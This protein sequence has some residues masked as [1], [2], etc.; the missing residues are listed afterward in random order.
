MKFLARWQFSRFSLTERIL[1]FDRLSL[2]LRAGIPITQALGHIRDVSPTKS[3]RR[4]LSGVFAIITHGTT[5][6]KTLESFPSHFPPFEAHL[7]AIGEMSGKLPDN[8]AH[9]ASLLRRQRTLKRKV[10][11]ALL[12][13]LIIAIGA[14]CVTGFLIFYLFPKIIPVFAGLNV[15]LPFTTRFLIG[16]SNLFANHGLLLF[17]V[18]IIILICTAML[19]RLRSVRRCIDRLMFMLPFIRSLIRTY[20]VAVHMR[21]LAMLLE[22]G[23][24]LMP[25][26]ALARS[27]ISHASYEAALVAIEAQVSAG[28][29]LSGELGKYPHLFPAVTVQLAA[30]GELTGTLSRSLA[31]C[32]DLYE[33]E[34][35]ELTRRLATLI[36]PALMI[37]VGGIVGFVAIAIISP[38]YGITQNLNLR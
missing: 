27:G 22:S 32:A 15:P 12:Y 23:I 2:Y 1:L 8:L 18:F 4:V 16:T 33:E 17:V 34:L 9:L 19:L 28:Q 21:T 30:A 11:G 31:S 35:E 37:F 6:A 36:E 24:P 10:R 5:L 13:P 20:H 7:I 38:V 26:L 3:S 25:A 14:V 29:K